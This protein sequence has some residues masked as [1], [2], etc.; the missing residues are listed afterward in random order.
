MRESNARIEEG[1]LARAYCAFD[2][3][4]RDREKSNLLYFS[5]PPPP[6]INSKT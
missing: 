3:V 1:V 6:R 2:F 5:A 4:H